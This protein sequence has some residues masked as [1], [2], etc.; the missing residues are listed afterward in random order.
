MTPKR[1]AKNAKQTPKKSPAPLPCHAETSSLPTKFYNLASQLEQLQ[2]FS[3]ATGSALTTVTSLH[4]TINYHGYKIKISDLIRDFQRHS[5]IEHKNPN[6][7][8][9][10]GDM[11]EASVTEFANLLASA[12]PNISHLAMG[13]A[14]GA[15][16]LRR[17]GILCTK[18][19]SV[20]VLDGNLTLAQKA[21]EK[22]GPSRGPI[23]PHLTHLKML[24]KMMDTHAGQVQ[25]VQQLLDC[26][27]VSHLELGGGWLD[28]VQDM[29]ILPRGIKTLLCNEL[30]LHSAACIMPAQ[31]QLG[32][33]ESVLIPAS[34]GT[35]P[36]NLT[37]LVSF[38]A[39]APFLKSFAVE[40]SS[41]GNGLIIDTCLPSVI[42]A[43]RHL[44][45]R[46]LAGFTMEGV[47]LLC[48][49]DESDTE[50]QLGEYL[51]LEQVIKRLPHLPSFPSCGLDHSEDADMASCLSATARLFPQLE[52]LLLFGDWWSGKAGLGKDLSF[53]CLKKLEVHSEIM[54]SHTMLSLVASAPQLNQLQ[55]CACVAESGRAKYQARLRATQVVAVGA[56]GG[57]GI[58][59]L[60]DWTL[61][62]GSVQR[63]FWTRE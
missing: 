12:C 4:L 11:T 44:Q 57:S 8:C 60:G 54:S 19:T 13:G 33:L 29:Q 10:P 58:S 42:G 24:H 20:E 9:D 52:F 25:R 1:P 5:T 14:V 38:L 18:L 2:Q 51:P 41:D 31:L 34:Q 59:E 50:E 62:A 36:V 63:M 27:N 56:D 22:A 53:P 61:E 40:D 28:D 7:P 35:Q 47:M 37:S 43:S 30:P 3:A 21:S 48:R 16:M 23:L 39:V 49:G 32:R 15:G 45:Q 26:P 17:F 6:R 46:M 55:H